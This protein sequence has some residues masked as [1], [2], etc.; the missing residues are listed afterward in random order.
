M[1]KVGVD[2]RQSHEKIVIASL[3]TLPVNGQLIRLSKSEECCCGYDPVV[4]FVFLINPIFIKMK[5]KDAMWWSGS[6]SVESIKQ[7]ETEDYA[8]STC[9][10]SCVRH[11]LRLLS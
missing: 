8:E 2:T 10:H 5:N 9:N 6:V 4:E 3:G 11:R 7:S 1:A